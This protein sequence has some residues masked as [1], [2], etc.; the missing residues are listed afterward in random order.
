MV[1][2]PQ[3]VS[4]LNKEAPSIDGASA[5]VVVTWFLADADVPIRVEKVRVVGY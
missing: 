5:H 2:C 3:V 4:S 1:K